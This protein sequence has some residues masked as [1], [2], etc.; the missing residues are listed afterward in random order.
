[1]SSPHL[2]PS[3]PRP[4]RAVAVLP[5]D[6]D[7]G[8]VGGHRL[9]LRSLEVWDG[10]ADLRFARIDEGATRPLPRRVPPTG[11]WRIT[12]DGEPV[13]VLD[14][15]GRGDREFSN[16]EV[17]LAPAPWPGGRLRVEVELLP[18]S[19]ALRG[20]VTLPRPGGDR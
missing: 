13:E 10:W 4:P 15:V 18:G 2:P 5:L 12:L 19:P 16:G 3:A 17:R 6:T 20:E 7:L 8:E 14:A 9:L 11:A 1:M